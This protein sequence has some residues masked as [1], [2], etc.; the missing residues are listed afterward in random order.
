MSSNLWPLQ[1]ADDLGIRS[2][3]AGD[4]SPTPGLDCRSFGSSHSQS[5]RTYRR[6]VP[7]PSCPALRRRRLSEPRRAAAYGRRTRGLS[8]SRGSPACFDAL[9][10][11]VGQVSRGNALLTGVGVYHESV[12]HWQPDPRH[13]HEVLP[14]QP[15]ILSV[16]QLPGSG[17]NREDARGCP[18]WRSSA[19]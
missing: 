1:A 18:H 12:G 13:P 7:C 11:F 3:S 19:S 4:R 10:E 14:L 16:G 5:N 8:S 2:V 9:H 6:R 17:D 15:D